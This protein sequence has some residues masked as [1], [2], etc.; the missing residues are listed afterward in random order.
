MSKN[1]KIEM[2]A[3]CSFVVVVIALMFGVMYIDTLIH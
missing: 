1:E 2:V 3:C